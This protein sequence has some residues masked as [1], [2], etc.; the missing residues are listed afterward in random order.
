MNEIP[1][2]TIVFVGMAFVA[3]AEKRYYARKEDLIVELLGAGPTTG[4]ILADVM[5][6]EFN[7]TRANAGSSLAYLRKKGVVE[8]VDGYWR[9]K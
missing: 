2:N 3:E 9:L 1:D 5:Q 7:C 6:K 8:L 4:K